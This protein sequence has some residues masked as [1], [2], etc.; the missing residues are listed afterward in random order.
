MCVISVSYT[1]IALMKQYKAASAVDNIALCSPRSD[2]GQQCWLIMVLALLAWLRE[3][4]RHLSF[5]QY[6]FAIATFL[7]FCQ[8]NSAIFSVFI[9]ISDMVS[10]L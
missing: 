3:K 5:L 7:S 10:R 8:S 9:I 2:G 6:V 1:V 4:V